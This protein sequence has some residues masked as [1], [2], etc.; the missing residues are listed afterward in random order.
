MRAEPDR[1]AAR[2]PWLALPVLIGSLLATAVG[3]APPQHVGYERRQVSGVAAHV[4]T[5]NLNEPSVRVGLA[6]AADLPEGD[7]PFAELVRK[8]RAVAAINGACFDK[9][10]LHPI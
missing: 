7:E 9:H 1:P 10:T 6:V 8:S 5:V 4:L 3:S 2:I